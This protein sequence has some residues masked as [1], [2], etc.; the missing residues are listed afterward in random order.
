MYIVSGYLQKIISLIGI[1]LCGGESSRM[2]SD[3]GLLLS[4]K[5]ITWAKLAHQKMAGLGLP[6]KISVNETQLMSYSKSFPDDE[7]LTDNQS[8]LFRGPL[9]GIM[10][11]HLQYPNEDLIVLAC[12][13][14]AMDPSVL[15]S[16]LV[17]LAADP[18]GEAYVF[19]NNNEPE[20]LC[21]IYTARG[22]SVIYT[23]M[24]KGS[25]SRHSMKF[26]LSQLQVDAVPATEGQKK[27]FQ[28]AK[29][30]HVLTFK[31]P[32]GRRWQLEDEARKKKDKG[33]NLCTLPMLEKAQPGFTD[34]FEQRFVMT[35]LCDSF[36]LL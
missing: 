13:M 20:P 30:Y 25:I 21:A 31:K 16:L 15:Q 35:R 1:I 27:Y 7:L 23:M 5:H 14:P 12:D 36:L 22:L 9:L 24:I 10:T 33:Y 18:S 32:G 19:T 8:L 29:V 28:K 26:I 11:S 3:K 34:A 6:V 17:R 2:G 4:G